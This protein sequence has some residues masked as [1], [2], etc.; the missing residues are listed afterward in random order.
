MRVLVVGSIGLDTVSGP[1]GHVT[2]TLG[3][4]VSFFALGAQAFA[5]VCIVS[6]VGQDFPERYWNLFKQEKIDCSGIQTLPGK[7][8]RWTGVYSEDMNIR[9]TKAVELNVLAE[10]DPT[11]PDAWRDV[12]FAFL[13]NIAPKIQL[14]ILDQLES[15]RF[16]LADTIDLWIN[17]QREALEEVMRR[18]DGVVLNESEMRLLTGKHNLITAAKALHEAGVKCVLVKKGEHGAILL[19][20]D[21]LFLIPAFPTEEVRDPT[22]AGD[23]FAGGLMGWLAHE[24]NVDRE[25]LRRAIAYGTIVA[26]FTVEQ[27][28]VDR[29]TGL[30]IEQ[31]D[32]RLEKFRGMVGF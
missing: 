29:L 11:V 24:G 28:S 25:T 31:I 1:C 20:D 27:F 30:T 12:P 8:F 32:A 9:E 2:E 7:T 22:G 6:V 10:F 15:P 3:G 18:V 17:T 14:K 23:S 21:D 4:S 5:D 26:S 19:T 13:A 16:V